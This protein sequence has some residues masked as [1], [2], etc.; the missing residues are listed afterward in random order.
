MK[1]SYRFM[2]P[3]IITMLILL[4]SA[5]VGIRMELKNLQHSYVKTLVD[6]SVYDFNLQISSSAQ[7]AL[8]QAA[9]LSK[10]PSIIAAY[11]VAHSGNPDDPESLEAQE[12]R[13]AI[14]RAA[15]P[16]MEGYKQVMGKIP[17]VHFH[18]SNNRSLVRLWRKKQTKKKGKWVDISDDLSSFRKTVVDVNKDGKSRLGIEL[19]RGGFTIRGIAPVKN[20]SGQ[21]L[22][23]V[24]VLHSLS[25]I[26]TRLKKSCM[27]NTGLLMN[28][29]QL[30]ITKKL[31]NTTEYPHLGDSFVLV[32]GKEFRKEMETAGVTFLEQGKK[33][34]T[35]MIL[36]SLAICATPVRDYVGKQ[37]GVLFFSVDVSEQQQLINYLLW[38]LIGGVLFLFV[39]IGIIMEFCLR[40]HITKP[41][42]TFIASFKSIEQGNYNCVPKKESSVEMT[43]FSKAIAG[44]SQQLQET[45]DKVSQ[46][47]QRALESAAEAERSMKTAQ[48]SEAKSEELLEKLS[49]TAN[50]AESLAQEVISALEELSRDIVHTI[51]GADMQ[52]QR[53]QETAAA[54][55][56]MTASVI[57]VASNAS[58]AAS[59]AASSKEK[60]LTGGEGVNQAVTSIKH[61]GESVAGLK[62]T[63]NDLDSQTES[64]GNVLN[65]INDI[66][67]QTNL[68][69]LNAAIEAARAGEAG[70]GFAVVADEV[71]KLAEKTMDATTEVEGVIQN[72]QTVAKQNIR[73]VENTA[74]ELQKSVELAHNS[75]IFMN[76][77]IHLVEETSSQVES[78]ATACEE[79]SSSSEEISSAVS[80]VNNV[81]SETAKDMQGSSNRLE[82]VSQLINK[83]NTLISD[84][85]KH[86]A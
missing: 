25:T 78:I 4:V 45:F 68:L 72:I 62:T 11:E 12:A 79:Q 67:D 48:Q 86:G 23:S 37:I 33:E 63:M 77:I 5:S 15:V 19:G 49:A 52:N 38:S 75:G 66:A 76:E 85:V 71:R 65:V 70:R 35:F 74:D 26:L 1:L 32:V 59:N 14:R 3:I 20:V 34:T 61:V 40:K 18:L 8:Q 53:L 58:N 44:L 10:E 54:L 13:E 41:F 55:E 51:E 43:L 69:A 22:G 6:A 46:E 56:Q 29:D 80:E 21:Q 2:I 47:Q 83:L 57:N 30:P 81:A 60:A 28:M 27:V 64:I 50:N 42:K 7:S 39:C 9:L 16:Y 24:E 73:A 31:Q 84:M 17:K 82:E 36:G